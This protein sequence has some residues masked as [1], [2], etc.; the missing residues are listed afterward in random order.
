ME[1]RGPLANL[2][3]DDI[4]W[5]HGQNA[6]AKALAAWR[7]EPGVAPVL[8]AMKRFGAG[9]PL[10][11]CKALALLFEPSGP[12]ARAFADSLVAAGL[13]AIDGYPLGQLP[14]RHGSRD[15]VPMLV[16]ARSGH[17]TL[18]LAAYDGHA[19]ASLPRPRTARFRPVETWKRVLAG[20][21]LADLVSRDDRGGLRTERIALEAGGV[22]RHHGSRQAFDIHAVDGAMVVL[23]LER[24]LDEHEPVREFDLADGTLLHQASARKEDSRG[25]LVVAL[26]GAMERIDAVPQIAGLAL[27]GGSDAL[28]WQAL[29]EVI[30]LDALA[31]VELLAHLASD[32]GDTLQ[33][34]AADQLATLLVSRPDL[35][36]AAP[37]RG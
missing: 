11:R 34:Q 10:E 29:R 22:Y 9:G 28:R 23:R 20:S 16:L 32:D 14:L 26:L 31:G 6:L 19:L 30:G 25:E 5:E 17:A 4:D 15:A 27:G 8:A 7:A 2:R 12:R 18:A 37:W 33:A 35:R 1:L 21:G 13:A 3:Q 24:Q 36:E